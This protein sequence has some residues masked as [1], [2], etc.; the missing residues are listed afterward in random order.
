MMGNVK[1]LRYRFVLL[2]VLVAIPLALFDVYT[3]SQEK[4]KRTAEVR[5]DLKMS[6][7]TVVEKISSLISASHDLLRGLTVAKEIK[8]GNLADCTSFLHEVGKKYPKYTN[9][10]FVNRTKFLVC[11]SGPLAKSIHLKKSPN[12]NAAFE[13]KKFA[14]SPFKF[15]VLTGK[16]IL[17]FSEPILD[18][19]NTILGT[20]NNGLSLTWLGKYL[21][22]VASIKDERI[23]VFDGTG[24]ILASYPKNL[25]A[26]GSNMGMPK[27]LANIVQQKTGAGLLE[28]DNGNMMIGAFASIPLVP[29][30]AFVMSLTPLKG[31]QTS[32]EVNLYKRLMVLGGFVAV[33]LLL[34]WMSAKVML[35][36]P[37]DRL[38]ILSERLA[39]GDLKARSNVDQ[40]AGEL[41]QLSISFDR[42]ASA[43]DA[44]TSALAHAKEE[45]EIANRAKS[46][47]LA[48]MSHELRTPL[49]AVLGFAQMLQFDPKNPLK[50]IQN[51]HVESIIEGGSHLLEL[52]NG[53]LDLAKIEADQL[54]LSVEQT[55][56]HEIIDHCIK[57]TA[58]IG[59]QQNIKISKDVATESTPVLQTDKVRFTQALLNLL[60]N[61][62]NYNK[63]GGTVLVSTETV[64]GF[65]RI[66]VTDTGVGIAKENFENVFMMFRRL[67]EDSMIA[68]EGTGIGL[69]VTKLLV[70]HMAG[71]IGFTSEVNV[72]STFWMALPLATNGEVLLW[73]DELRVGVDAIDRDHQVL[74]GLTNKVAQ[75]GV[76]AAILNNVIWDLI[77]YTRYHFGR[78]EALMKVCGYPNLE[79]HQAQ[80]KMLIERATELAEKW[81]ASKNDDILHDLRTFLKTWWLAHIV[82]VDTTI[83]AYAKG[84]DMEI[85][86]ALKALG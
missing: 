55:D 40:R 47:F 15:G 79:E 28:M 60:S 42:M 62:V 51:E 46:E 22:T 61:A 36:N 65:L 86:K 67:D 16:P 82:N 80:H 2:I 13:N 27:L 10:S 5:D 31:V 84:K 56:A 54:S 50:P 33:S 17:V 44:R 24:T 52:V 81:Y 3:A 25:Y 73:T 57:L 9:F 7:Q 21:P 69:T 45:A 77:D 26:V 68:R 19:Q 58:P 72:G 71:S 39:R 23:V 59:I 35:I 11:S 12:I 75:T 63:A 48:C 41:G 43:L 20:L 34:G 83:A 74:I 64:D 76:D 18:A 4:Q 6:A 85:R 29:N 32:V 38:I 53:V 14:V 49:N 30:G 1:S 66:S 8:S 37:I 70:E 78:E